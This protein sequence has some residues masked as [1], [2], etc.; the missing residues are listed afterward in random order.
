MG[1]APIRP[2]ISHLPEDEKWYQFPNSE[3]L[4]KH[5]ETTLPLDEF[6]WIY[7]DNTIPN[8]VKS[9][10]GTKKQGHEIAM[11]IIDNYDFFP[12]MRN[13][14]AECACKLIET[15]IVAFAIDD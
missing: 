13:I 2:P 8:L 5:F 9:C 4:S 7:V 3:T 11:E 14:N 10:A 15:S 12:G 1:N 6:K